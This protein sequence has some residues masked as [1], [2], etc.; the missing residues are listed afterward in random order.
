MASRENKA[1]TNLLLEEIAVM[2]VAK[3][4]VVEYHARGGD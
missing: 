3:G 1:F 4:R 2:F